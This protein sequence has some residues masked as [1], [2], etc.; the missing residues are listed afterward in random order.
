MGHFSGLRILPGQREHREAQLVTV[1][2]G[3]FSVAD[4]LEQQ[5]QVGEAG[6]GVGPAKG[7]IQKIMQRKGRQPF[8]SADNFGDLHQV[9]VHD[10][11]QVVGGQF[12]GPFPQHFVVQGVGVHFH[13]AADEVVHLDD[14]VFR[15]LEAN[16]PVRGLFQQALDF[17]LGQ[18]EGIAQFLAGGGVVHEGVALGLGGGAALIEVV[19]AVKG[20]I[21]PAGGHQ[22][23][24]ILPIDGAALA[25]AVRRVRMLLTG[26]FHHLA[27]LV[28]AFVGNDPAPA[29]GFDD[30]GFGPR[31]KTV[32]VGVLDADDEISAF[33]LGIQVVIQCRTHTAHMQR[34]SG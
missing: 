30:V 10:V 13:V 1:S 11:G 4:G 18:S 15:H 14:A 17:G 34:A 3:E 9:V 33:L 20:V 22:L 24:G 16:G 12:I 7:L 5:G 25:L 21:G 6:H 32:G 28:Y 26:Y 19:C 23:L 27:V 8:L 2:L 31:H 29:Q